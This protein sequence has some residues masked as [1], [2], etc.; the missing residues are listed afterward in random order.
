MK[1]VTNLDI[2]K[3]SKI[4]HYYN[5]IN[6]IDEMDNVLGN[7]WSKMWGTER[8]GYAQLGLESSGRISQKR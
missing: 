7:N 6:L 8:N 1:K 5:F 3:I 2:V 4:R